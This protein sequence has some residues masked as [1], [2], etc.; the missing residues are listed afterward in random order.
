MSYDN[1]KITHDTPIYYDN[2]KITHDTP[3]YYD[4]E[5]ITPDTPIY[6]DAVQYKFSDNEITTK[7]GSNNILLINSDIVVYKMKNKP[8]YYAIDRD[9]LDMQMKTP[10]YI[11]F[12]CKNRINDK[13]MDM[14]DIFTRDYS[15]FTN[16]HNVLPI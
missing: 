11:W 4:N 3:I 14:Q 15:Y 2:E 5:E 8:G 16:N 10:E 7:Y 9:Q 13:Q 6:Y 1:E 12:L